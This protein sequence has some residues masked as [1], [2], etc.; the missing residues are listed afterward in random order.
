M[1]LTRLAWLPQCGLQLGAVGFRER[2]LPG[3]L[4]RLAN[5]LES[6]FHHLDG[7]LAH[8]NHHTQARHMSTGAEKTPHGIGTNT[9]TALPASTPRTCFWAGVNGGFLRLDGRGATSPSVYNRRTHAHGAT[10]TRAHNLGERRCAR[11]SPAKPPAT[12]RVHA[13][14]RHLAARALCGHH[15]WPSH[16]WPLL[17]WSGGAWVPHC[18][19]MMHTRAAAGHRLQEQVSTPTTATRMHR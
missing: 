10:R 15:P 12:S 1:R 14:C 19:C 17:P 8:N 6:A 18:T 11:Q 13:P 9:C 5:A 2:L 3:T 16:P 4:T 7:S